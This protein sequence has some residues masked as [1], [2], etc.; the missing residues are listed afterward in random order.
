MK[1]I[2]GWPQIAKALGRALGCSV[3]RRTAIR[4]AQPGRRHRLPVFRYDNGRVYLLPGALRLWV[5]TRSMPLGGRL[6]GADGEH[7]DVPPRERP[8]VQRPHRTQGPNTKAVLDA[9]GG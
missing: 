8:F 2:C 9:R 6:P 1:P 3:S 5:N 7:A 4:Y